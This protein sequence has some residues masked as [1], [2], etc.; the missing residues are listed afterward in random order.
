MTNARAE[1]DEIVWLEHSRDIPRDLSPYD[2]R[3]GKLD[4]HLDRV[5]IDAAVGMP[6][7]VAHFPETETVEFFQHLYAR[8]HDQV[9]HIE[10]LAHAVTVIIAFRKIIIAVVCHQ[11]RLQA[12]LRNDHMGLVIAVLAA[13]HGDHAVII[14]RPGFSGFFNAP[15]KQRS[16][17]EPKFLGHTL[18]LLGGSAT[19]TYALFIHGKIDRHMRIDTALT[20][21]HRCSRHI[22]S[23]LQQLGSPDIE[24]LLK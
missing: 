7:H 22:P 8:P 5:G 15:F 14:R 23:D 20:I 3:D 24:P 18:E 17:L 12:I 13:A 2:K 11:Q 9:V 16:A 4:R 1:F 10:N 19:R 6:I 21:L